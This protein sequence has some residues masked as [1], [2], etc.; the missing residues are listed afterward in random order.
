MEIELVF[1][2]AAEV[3]PR[4]GR[5]RSKFF[6][7]ISKGLWTPGVELG[8][9]STAWPKHETEALMAARLT[10]KSPEEQIAIVQRLVKLR[11]ELFAKLSAP[12]TSSSQ[13]AA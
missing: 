6:E 9:N 4:T 5:S 3:I 8:P 2:R 13:A 10:G 11:T 12:I 1:E 7:D